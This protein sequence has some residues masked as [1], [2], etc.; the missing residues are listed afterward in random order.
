MTTPIPPATRTPLVLVV[1]DVELMRELLSLQLGRAGCRFEAVNDGVTALQALH[2][3]PFDMVLMDRAMP[4]MDGCEATQSWRAHEQKLGLTPIPIIGVGGQ[5]DDRA[6]C[7]AAGM[8]EFVTK[9]LTIQ[10]LDVLLKRYLDY[11]R[12]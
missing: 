11:P 5:P 2:N 10:A 1:D 9:P 3:R 8:H 12:A 4:F 7:M 6:D